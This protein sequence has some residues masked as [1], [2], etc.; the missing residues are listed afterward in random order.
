M[1]TITPTE[2]PTPSPSVT[3]TELPTTKAPSPSPS[4]TPTEPPTPAPTQTPTEI[5]TSAPIDCGHIY[6]FKYNRKYRE[7]CNEAP[8]CDYHTQHGCIPCIKVGGCKECISNDRHMWGKEY[9]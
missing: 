7:R 3:P 5:P 4:H 9:C 2:P 6:P 1:G 8:Q